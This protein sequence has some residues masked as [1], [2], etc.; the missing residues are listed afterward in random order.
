MINVTPAL[1]ALIAQVDLPDAG[2]VTAPEEIQMVNTVY[3]SVKAGDWVTVAAAL[4][5]VSVVIIRKFGKQLHEM[6][7]DDNPVDKVFWFFLETKLGGWVLNFLT[8]LTG[9]M[10]SALMAGVAVNWE[11]LKP[12]V[13]VSLTGA[14]LWEL[15][16]DI[17]EFVKKPEA[18]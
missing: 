4:L 7:D 16:K 18:K 11:L 9:A 15:F 14:S 3:V 8:S 17:S 10:G 2:V 1:A 13:L 5:V 12:T 6:I